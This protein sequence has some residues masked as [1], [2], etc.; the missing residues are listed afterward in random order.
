[1]DIF[2]SHNQECVHS[3]VPLRYLC[4]CPFP[5][6]GQIDLV[7]TGQPFHP[8]GNVTP[9]SYPTYCKRGLNP[10]YYLPSSVIHQRSSDCDIHLQWWLNICTIEQSQNSHLKPF[11]DTLHCQI[12]RIAMSVFGFRAPRQLQ[13]EVMHISH[14]LV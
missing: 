1:M 9:T 11:Q 13:K 7:L 12:E 6:R 3:Q 4:L 2:A 14:A 5:Q 10:L 8:V